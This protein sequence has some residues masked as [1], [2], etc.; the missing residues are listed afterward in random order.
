MTSRDFPLLFY[1]ESTHSVHRFSADP[2]LI[3][4][5]VAE[6]AALQK[7]ASNE[8]IS[9]SWTADELSV[10]LPNRIPLQ[11][12]N[13]DASHRVEDGWALMKVENPIG[14]IDFAVVGLVSDITAVLK[15]AA[16]SVF[17][18]SSFDT[19]WIMIKQAQME[20]AQ[21]SLREDGWTVRDS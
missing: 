12:I 2:T 17:V 15:A 20:Q 5:L 3:T 16:I 9:I 14:G 10:T 1:R 7:P 18:I 8:L 13:R 19:D 6:L 4:S 11:V 21:S